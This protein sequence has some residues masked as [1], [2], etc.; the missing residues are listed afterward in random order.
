[1]K[2]FVFLFGLLASQGEEGTLSQAE[3]AAEASPSANDAGEANAVLAAEAQAKLQAAVTVLASGEAEQAAIQ[4]APLIGVSDALDPMVH[5][6]LGKALYKQGYFFAALDQMERVLSHPS[7]GE[8]AGSALEWCLFI[9]RRMADDA[10]VFE[11]LLR[12]GQERL[13][14]RYRGE[15]IFRLARYHYVQALKLDRLQIEENQKESEKKEDGISF[16]EDLF[17]EEAPK[18]K[19]K[20]A[21][22][23]AKRRRGRARAKKKKSIRIEEDLFGEAA[24]ES[25]SKAEAETNKPSEQKQNGVA[26]AEHREAARRLLLRIDPNSRFVA[27]A[28]FLN[29]LL[30]VQARQENQALEAFKKV[31]KITKEKGSNENDVRKRTRLR[32]RELA[33]FQLARLHFGASQPTFSIFY[34]RKV[35]RDSLQWLDALYEASWAEY[36]LNRH[37]RA[38]GNLLTVNA[39]FFKDAYYPESI[40]LKAVIYYENCRYK[41][42]SSITSDFLTTYEP[43]LVELE[44]LADTEKSPEAWYAMLNSLEETEADSD[45]AKILRIALLDPNLRRIKGSLAELDA[46]LSAFGTAPWSKGAGFDPIGTRLANLQTMLRTEAGRSVERRLRL[47]AEGIKALV[48]QGL[49]IRAETADAEGKR[50][51]A[52]LARRGQKPKRVVRK[53]ENYT[54]D[55][56]V[57]WPFEG[58]YWRDELGTYELSLAET[59]L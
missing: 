5:Y 46:E 52:S 10:R 16:E 11:A 45:V 25:E 17:S 29:G 18:P 41:E 21:P 36:R 23:R 57:I 27:A 38:L 44:T 9:G 22:P 15:Y 3:E 24:E 19:P 26:A 14:N 50:L 56:K 39:P 30:L 4:L 53:V 58:E 8:F 37:E 32:L 6:H 40:I 47:E 13:P 59:C 12:S 1:M 54:D 33:L 28:E 34:Y 7:A 31:V 20:K 55:E 49:R 2:V 43:V 35:N 42:A 48:S 51:E